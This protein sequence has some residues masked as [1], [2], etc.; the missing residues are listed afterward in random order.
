MKK[1]SKDLKVSREN[2]D[3]KVILVCQGKTGRM[4]M[5]EAQVSLAKKA[6]RG[7]RANR[8]KRVK[9]ELLDQLDPKAPEAHV[10]TVVRKVIEDQQE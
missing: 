10:D 5:T 7:I 1:V 3:L 8:E 9:L 6:I 4:E 2:K